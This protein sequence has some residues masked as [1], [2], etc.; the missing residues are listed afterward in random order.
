MQSFDLGLYLVT[1]STLTGGR[2]LLQIV[3]E[4]AEAGVTMVQLREK[5]SNTRD[6]YRTAVAMKKLLE[7]YHIPLIINDRIDIALACEA[8]G[9]HIGQKDMPYT[10]ARRLLGKERIIGLSVESREQAIE[11]DGLDIDYIGISPVF[12]TP[13]KTDT[14]TP[15]GLEGIRQIVE[16]CRH[17]AVGIGG[18][19]PGNAGEIIRAGAQGIAVVSA[20][21]SAADV[22]AATRELKATIEKERK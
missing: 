17:P 11:A 19:H 14:A 9:L 18:I 13:T 3:E 12:G 8:D 16:I 4:A 10:E 1:D 20:I 2:P 5:E 22:K 7:S 15:L 21:I 6:F